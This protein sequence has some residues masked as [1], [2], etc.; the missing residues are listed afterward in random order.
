MTG[1]PVHEA[2]RVDFY[3]SHEGL[4]LPYE[5]A[6]TRYIPRARNWYNLSTHLPWIGMRTAQLD[7]AHVEYF[8]GIANP[9]GVKV[10]A[11]MDD[12]LAAGARHHAEPEQRARPADAHPS[13]RREGD[14]ADRCRG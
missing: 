9:V 3:A 8:R 4:L 7:G 6:Q 14:R 2:G 13:L 10:G 12:A 11:A 5:Q 1:A